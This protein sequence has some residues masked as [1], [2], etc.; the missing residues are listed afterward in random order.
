MDVTEILT[1]AG[2]EIAGPAENVEKAISII[3]TTEV[4]AAILDI[5][6]QGQR[7]DDL[8]LELTRRNIPFAFLSGYGRDGLPPGFG[9]ALLI[10]KPF[11]AAQILDVVAQLTVPSTIMLTRLRQ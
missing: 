3:N 7:V 9:R 4:D 2:C 10:S 11:N 5:N 1:E 8:A 6:L